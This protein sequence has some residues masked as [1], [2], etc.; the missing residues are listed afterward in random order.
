MLDRLHRDDDRN[1][2]RDRLG[3]RLN[4]WPRSFGFDGPHAHGMY[5]PLNRSTTMRKTFAYQYL[6]QSVATRRQ[7][8]NA[9]N[10]NMK[11][12]IKIRFLYSE[13]FKLA[14][15]GHL[16]KN[17]RIIMFD[18]VRH[19]VITI[20]YPLSLKPHMCCVHTYNKQDECGI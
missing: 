15:H 2:Q 11:K 13:R 3:R 8:K 10:N 20:R 18:N 5:Q 12:K 1:S 9:T 17:S 7:Q 16:S 6:K 19:Q 14:P 4:T